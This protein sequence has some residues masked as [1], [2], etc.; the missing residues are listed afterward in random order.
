MDQVREEI[1][2]VT[3]RYSHDTTLSLQERL[4]QV[5]IEAWESEFPIIDASLKDSIR[6]QLIGTAYRKNT[7]GFDITLDK[8]KTE[9]IPNGAYATLSAG[10]TF[11]DPD[12]FT[13]PWEWDPNRYAPDRA[14]DKKKLYAWW[15]WGH[16]RH[17]CVG[18]RFAKLEVTLIV[19]FFLA[20]FV[21]INLVDER[22]M[23]TT[24]LPHIDRNRHSPHV[25]SERVYLKYRARPDGDDK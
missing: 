21:D 17:P 15:G 24:K 4:K 16:A 25:P 12:I 3:D 8:D 9:V 1:R 7:S 6:L 19:A 10:V 13:S 11:Y 23:P 20:Y 2:S 14:E 18:M 5:P 22:G